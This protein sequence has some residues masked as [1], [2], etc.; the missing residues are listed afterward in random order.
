MSLFAQNGATGGLA[1][2]LRFAIACICAVCLLA[3]MCLTVADV[4]GRY[5][6]NAPVPGAAEVTELLLATFVFIGLPA[7]SIDKDHI[8]VDVVTSRFSGTRASVMEIAVSIVSACVLAIVAWR[9]WIVG[10]QI[11]GYAGTTPTLK[12]PLAPV[13]YGAAVLCLLAA[14]VTVALAASHWRNRHG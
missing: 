6:M 10:N 7:A 13:A 3:M 4:L 9:I 12:L 2:R 14:I 1:H 8:A 5:I 11:A